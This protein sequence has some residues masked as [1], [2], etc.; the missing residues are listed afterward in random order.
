MPRSQI[1]GVTKMNVN[2]NK[3]YVTLLICTRAALVLKLKAKPVGSQQQ[4]G[5]LDPIG[6]SDPTRT[7]FPNHSGP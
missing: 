1:I 4:F 6:T 3:H 5:N 7:T 2:V